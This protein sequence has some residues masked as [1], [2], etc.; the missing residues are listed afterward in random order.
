MQ[1]LL[2]E[3]NE[4]PGRPTNYQQWGFYRKHEHVQISTIM[5]PTRDDCSALHNEPELD[6]VIELLCGG[7]NVPWLKPKGVGVKEDGDTRLELK[8]PIDN[9]IVKR[10]LRHIDTQQRNQWEPAQPSMKLEQIISNL[11]K[12]VFANIEHSA[13]E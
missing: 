13:I 7:V 11:E 3:I 4:K 10:Y 6:E 8:G 12:Q 9:N 1:Y 5:D 2:R